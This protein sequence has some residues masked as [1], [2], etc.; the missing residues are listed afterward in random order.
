MW[1]YL[2]GIRIAEQSE[3]IIGH[4]NLKKL[5]VYKSLIQP[6]TLDHHSHS[7]YFQENRISSNYGERWGPCC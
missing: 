6:I 4:E 3:A 1:L 5:K 7:N 2:I